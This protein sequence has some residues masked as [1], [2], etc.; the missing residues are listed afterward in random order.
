M[1]M[2]LNFVLEHSSTLWR[3]WEPKYR[4]LFRSKR[5]LPKMTLFFQIQETKQIKPLRWGNTMILYLWDLGPCWVFVFTYYNGKQQRHGKKRECYHQSKI[6]QLVT[7][8]YF[9]PR[10]WFAK[11]SLVSFPWLCSNYSSIHSCHVNWTPSLK[12]KKWTNYSF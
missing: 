10:R 1:G 3:F 8:L 11:D 12:K 7:P 5:D 6:Q 2:L 9:E 4:C